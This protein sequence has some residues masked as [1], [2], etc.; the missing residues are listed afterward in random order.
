LIL[1]IVQV[2]SLAYFSFLAKPAVN[3]AASHARQTPAVNP[4]HGTPLALLP[5][6]ASSTMKILSKWELI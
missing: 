6:P 5:T 3:S 2:K 4:G 1:N